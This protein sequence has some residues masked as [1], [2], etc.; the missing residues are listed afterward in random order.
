MAG[1]TYPTVDR[2]I[3]LNILS[4]KLLPVKRGD[5]ARILN[6]IK[7]SK[8]ISDCEN[9]DGDLYAKAAL[10]LLKLVREHPFA[11][12]NRRT[13]FLATKDF[14]HSN[15]GDFK[16]SNDAGQAII[17]LGIREGYYTDAEIQEWIKHGKIRKFKR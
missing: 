9:L 15:E 13:A 12:G 14:I 2:V 5:K 3:E 17:L 16:I 8:I 10:L 6:V 7:I 1:Y 4:L 11:S